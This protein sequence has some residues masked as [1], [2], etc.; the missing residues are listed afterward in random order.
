MTILAWLVGKEESDKI[1]RMNKNTLR[2][3][4]VLALIAG[5]LW[6]I[7]L[8]L[9]KPTAP[10]QVVFVSPSNH[11]ENISTVS[12]IKIDFN[13][14]IEKNEI[15]VNL[16]PST[17]TLI[18]FENNQKTLTLVPKK[19]FH[20]NTTYTIEVFNKNNKPLWRS[21]FTTEKLQGD[22]TIPYESEKYTQTN[23]PLLEFIPYE[24]ESFSVTYSQPLTLKVTLK[25]GTKEIIESTVLNWIKSHGI[26]PSTHKIDWVTPGP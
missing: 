21:F 17:E 6:G 2:L 12:K 20:S 3:I 14:P 7:K 26:D 4:F 9:L 18:S 5:I 10:P 24:T 13:Q 19:P 23:Y 15:N 11:E 16:S 25:K 1:R 22:P 8:F